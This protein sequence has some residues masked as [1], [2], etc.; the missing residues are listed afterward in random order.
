[1][2][3]R[4]DVDHVARLARLA[5][6]DA[7]K[8]LMRDQLNA[9]LVHIDALRAVDTEGVEPTSHAVPLVNVMRDDEPRECLSQDAAL[10]NAPDRA[11]E[12]FRVPRIIED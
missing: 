4:E 3:S 8:V 7:E 1:M 12:F 10:A 11:G 2:I 5:L 6:T 9:I